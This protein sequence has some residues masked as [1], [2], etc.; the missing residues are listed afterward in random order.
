MAEL[1]TLDEKIG[2][3]LGLANGRAGRDRQGR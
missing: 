2:E 3:V 1:T